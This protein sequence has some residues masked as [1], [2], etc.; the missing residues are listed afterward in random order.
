M[1]ILLFINKDFEANLAYNYLKEELRKHKVKIYYSE[2]VGKKKAKPKELLQIEFFEK[3][4]IYNDLIATIKEHDISTDF[5]FLNEDFTSFELSKCTAVN[6][7]EFI[8]EIKKIEPDLFISIRFGK[9]FKDEIIQL[10]K[11]GILNLHSAILPDYKGIM[12]TL[13]N[14]KDNKTE[15][16]CTLHYIDS[17]T[18]DTGEIIAIAKRPIEKERS[19]LWH[20]VKLYPMGCDLI[21]DSLQKL[22]TVHRLPS[23]KQNKSKGNYFSLPKL[24]DFQQLQHRGIEGFNT[25]DYK[26]LL[27]EYISPELRD[28]LEI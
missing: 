4:F 15:Y 7:P 26:E 18:I 17:N 19:L 21:L 23:N 12:G 8:D 5:E 2:A 20:V 16:G 14:L 1:N 22:K 6:T 27:A 3:E 10:P 28:K 11:Q 24:E 25:E 9:I 13:H